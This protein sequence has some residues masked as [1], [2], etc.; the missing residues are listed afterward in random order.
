MTKELSIIDQ[1]KKLIINNEKAFQAVLPKNFDVQKFIATFCLEVQKNDKL[2][3]CTNLIE[4]ARDVANFGLIIG[5]LA[6]QAYLIPYWNSKKNCYVAQLIIGYRGYITKL[7]EA[8]YSVEVEIVTNEE[9]N[10]GCFQE[11]RGSKTEIIHR[12]IRKG[13]RDRE[14][15]ALA[16]CIIKSSNGSQVISVLSKEEIEEMGKTEKWTGSKKEG[17]LKKERGLSD[18][19]L[20]DDRTTDFGQQCMKTVIRNCAKKTNLRIA[21][22]MSAYEGQRD[23]EI[24]KDVSP[25]KTANAHTLPA[26]LQQAFTP[27]PDLA[28]E[29]E[30]PELPLPPVAPREPAQTDIEEFIDK[31][32]ETQDR[33]TIEARADLIHKKHKAAIKSF[34]NINGLN[35]YFDYLETKTDLEYLKTNTPELEADLQSVRNLQLAQIKGE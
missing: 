31:K 29:A 34:K 32:S 25:S 26:A 2:A 30:E 5:G 7:E 24:M 23:V 27:K 21:N 15:I 8:G 19:W 20:N 3:Q 33:E 11:I 13:I 17:N 14:N 12:P 22:E 6:N 4:V 16:Y 35:K 1:A 18:V 28:F 9:V 10:T